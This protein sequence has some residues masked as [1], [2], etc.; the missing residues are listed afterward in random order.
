[1]FSVSSFYILYLAYT[2]VALSR[3]LVILIKRSVS[4]FLY[5]STYGSLKVTK[6]K[7]CSLRSKCFRTVSEQRTR[8]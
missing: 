4:F 8:K 5:K 7:H 2:F 3:K 6:A 1:M